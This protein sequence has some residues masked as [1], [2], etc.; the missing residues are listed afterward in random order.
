LVLVISQYPFNIRSRQTQAGM[1]VSSAISHSIS[2]AAFQS[3]HNWES[4][5][6]NY[7]DGEHIFSAKSLKREQFHGCPPACGPGHPSIISKLLP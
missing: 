1:Q 3:R 2:C 4:T 6:A 7:E 5:F